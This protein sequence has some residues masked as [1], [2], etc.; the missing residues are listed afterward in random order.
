MDRIYILIPPPLRG[1][2]RGGYTPKAYI[3]ANFGELSSSPSD[4]PRIFTVFGMEVR[5]S[6]FQAFLPPSIFYMMQ[7]SSQTTPG[8]NPPTLEEGHGV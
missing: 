1:Q 5:S 8:Q 6:S 3:Q 4:S 2:G 7:E